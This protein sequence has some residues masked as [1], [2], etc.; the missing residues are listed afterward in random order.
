MAVPIRAKRRE[1]DRYDVLSLRALL[2]LRDRELDLLALDQRLEAV[3]LDRA[4]VCEHVWARF[5]GDEAKTLGL[6]EPFHGSGSCGHSISRLIKVKNDPSKGRL[7][8]KWSDY[9]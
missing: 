3:T 2:T 4:E 7:I 5:L 6:V 1:L 8:W 9:L